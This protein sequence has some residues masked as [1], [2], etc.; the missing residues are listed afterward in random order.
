MKKGRK[1]IAGLLTLGMLG[2]VCIAGNAG[3]AEAATAGWN[4]NAKGWWYTYSDGSYAK[5][6]WVKDGGKWYYFDG[7]GYMVTGWKKIS[8]K[9]Y[10]FNTSGA[11]QTG[12]KQINGK[13]YFFANGVMSTG[14][15][16]ING[17]WYFFANGAMSIRW[18]KI[19]GKWYYFSDDGIMM[20]GTQNIN[21]KKYVFSSDGIW[22]EGSSA[23]TTALSSANVGDYVIFGSY[24]QD[25]NTANGKESIRWQVLAKEGGKL[26]IVSE[27]GLDVQPYNTKETSVTWET[28]SLRTWLNK[29][30]YNAAFSSTEKSKIQTTSVANVN[31]S[32]HGTKGGKTTKDKVFLLSYDEIGEYYMLVVDSDGSYNAALCCRPTEYAE[33]KGAYIATDL[34]EAYKYYIGNGSCWLRTPGYIQSYATYVSTAGKAYTRGRSVSDKDVSICPAIWITP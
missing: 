26:L 2:S 17:K 31:N 12:W 5:S 34:T 13:W 9:W 19:S 6:A 1:L 16:K 18:K 15:K 21:G 28:C 10:Y 24:E 11:M 32:T 8:G 20:T 14:W 4:H 22:L 33:S 23:G 29:D 30:F 3:T 7:S 27:Y 25:N